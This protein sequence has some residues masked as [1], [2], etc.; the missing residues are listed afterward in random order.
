MRDWAG[1]RVREDALLVPCSYCG[2]RVGELCTAKGDP[3]H[4]LRAWPAHDVRVRAGRRKAE[5]TS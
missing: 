1:T 4:V 3:S 2:A 5:A